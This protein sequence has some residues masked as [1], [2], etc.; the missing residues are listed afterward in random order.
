MNYI[1]ECITD[2]G[3][4]TKGRG[5]WNPGRN[6]TMEPHFATWKK[7]CDNNKRKTERRTFP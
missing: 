6:F 3:L 1:A 4:S 2:P 5:P 7:I